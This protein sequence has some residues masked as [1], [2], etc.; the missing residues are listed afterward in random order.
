V[1]P[2]RTKR[3]PREDEPSGFAWPD[4]AYDDAASRA[5]GP[6][7]RDRR[8]KKADSSFVTE[9]GASVEVLTPK[10]LAALAG[11]LLGREMDSLEHMPKDDLV[12]L[13]RRVAR[14]KRVKIRINIDNGAS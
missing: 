11:Q 10:Q 2:P 6:P 9:V 14:M 13:V 5:D 12:D 8:R 4:E 3:P 1:R 7:R